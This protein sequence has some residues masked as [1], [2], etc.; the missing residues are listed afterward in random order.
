MLKF[1]YGAVSMMLLMGAGFFMW[2]SQAESDDP[3]PPAPPATA[4]NYVT[5]LQQPVP[6]LPSAPEMYDPI[7]P[8]RPAMASNY[9]A[10]LQQPVPM[11]PSAPAKSKEEKRFAPADKHDDGRITRA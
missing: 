11:P 6:M 9:V 4:A 7:P 5:P 2:K 3:I 1:I 8:R 10:P